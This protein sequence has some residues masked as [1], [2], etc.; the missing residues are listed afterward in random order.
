MLEWISESPVIYEVNLAENTEKE[1]EAYRAPT[2][3]RNK[4][5]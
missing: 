4:I 3:C 2:V 5:F 1:N